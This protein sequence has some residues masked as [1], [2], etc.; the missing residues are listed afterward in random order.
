M[1]HSDNSRRGVLGIGAGFA[2]AS[3]TLPAA[4]QQPPRAPPPGRQMLST[5]SFGA[6]GDAVADDS[7]PLQAALDAAFAPNGPGFLLIPPGTYKVSRTLRVA[8]PEGQRGDLTRHHGISAH[9]ARLLST[10]TDGSNVLEFVSRST[11]GS[12]SWAAVARATGSTLRA[13]TRSIIST[14]S[15]CATWSCRRAAVTAA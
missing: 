11:K 4:A 10:I 6:V 14:I 3:L 12:T 1:T 9:G 8:S 7:A 13:S 2:L 5:A 15:A